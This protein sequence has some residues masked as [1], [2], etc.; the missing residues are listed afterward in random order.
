VTHLG[1]RKER[2]L[3]G[4]RL[5]RILGR[6]FSYR[7]KREGWQDSNLFASRVPSLVYRNH[8]STLLRIH[9]MK[10]SLESDIFF[11]RDLKKGK[12]RDLT[13]YSTRKYVH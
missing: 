2:E 4:F 11:E 12:V 6:Y 1:N 7:L 3:I 13:I 9:M 10:T 8:T 5:K